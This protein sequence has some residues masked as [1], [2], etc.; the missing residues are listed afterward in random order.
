MNEEN[1][2]RL[3]PV[4][5]YPA[6][7]A[8]EAVEV[9]TEARDKWRAAN[10]RWGA[11]VSKESQETAKASDALAALE[12]AKRGEDPGA[13][14]TPAQDRLAGEVAKAR[15]SVD[16]YG[17]LMREAWSIAAQAIRQVAP[18]GAAHW[19]AERDARIKEARSAADRLADA[20][21]RVSNA[22]SAVHYFDSAA[23]DARA[24]FGGYGNG[25]D[26][27]HVT[28]APFVSALDKAAAIQD[29]PQFRQDPVDV[30]AQEAAAPGVTV[31]PRRKRTRRKTEA[32]GG[33]EQ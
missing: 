19:R 30:P 9:F 13:V 12:A 4:G 32:T 7:T 18:E 28:V 14:G 26:L 24:D 23:V 17:S 31:K 3:A 11:L 15:R 16:T 2:I 25:V 5:A 1:N 33:G 10:S 8:R 29:G 22:L 20:Q 21:R 27:D 6:G